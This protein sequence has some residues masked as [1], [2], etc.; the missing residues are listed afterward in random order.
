MRTC[1]FWAAATAASVL[2]F[3]S[4][5]S[6]TPPPE[7][8][9]FTVSNGVKMLKFTPAP[10]I[11]SYNIRSQ[12][13]VVAPFTND[14]SGSIS[15]FSFRVTNNAP[16]KFYNVSA[17]PMSSNNLLIANLLNRIAFGPTPDELQR[18]TNI[19][20]Q[21]YINEQLA[22]DTVVDTLDSYV[23]DTT[24]G[25][26]PPSE[27]QWRNVTVDGAFTATNF[28]V[29]LLAGG[30]AY[31][32]DIELRA[33]DRMITTN[34]PGVGE[35]YTTNYVLSTNLFWNGDFESATLNPW[36]KTAN[37]NNSA[38]STTY[39]HSGS[40][41][42]HLV[43]AT[44]GSTVTDS[45]V[46]RLTNLWFRFD[47]RSTSNRLSFWYLQ[48]TNSSRIKLRLSGEGVNGSGSDVP[49]PPQWI[50]GTATG[51][52]SS[53][54]TIYLYLSGAGQCYVDD[55]K[56]VAGSVPE[57]GVNIARNGD[58]ESPL[59]TNN[60]N[61]TADFTGSSIN[62]NFTHSGAGSLKIVA[63]GAGNGNGDAIFQTN[64]VG[65]TAGAPYT[66]SFWYLPPSN[67]RSLTCRLSGSSTPG[68][69]NANVADPDAPS[70]LRRR[71]DTIR[72]A[73]IDDGTV[74]INTLGGAQ[75][76]DLRSWFVQHC[77][78]DN[79]QLLHVLLQ[80]LENHFVTQS[81]K[82]V[83]Y[84]DRFY[85][86]TILE[87][88]ATD[89]EYREVTKWR[90]ALL[91]P[92]C[93]FYDL[94]RISAESPAMVV[95]LD[96]VDSNGNGTSI[97][98]E[99]YAR[100]IMELFCM[101]V[102]NGYDQQD[103][104]V[105]SRAWSGWSVEIVDPWNINNPHATKASRVGF[106]PGVGTGGTSNLVGVWTF[107]YKTNSHGTNRAAVWSIWNT[108]TVNPQPI[109]VKTVP[110]RFGPP[111]AGQP[112][113]LY[114]TNAVPVRFTTNGIND[115][116]D[117]LAKIAD[118]PFTMEFISVKLCRLFVHDDFVHGVYDYTD[119]NRSAEAELVRQCMIAW[120]TPVGGRK[121]NIR[122]ILNTIFNS[123]LFRSH[124]G[125]LQKVKTPL[126]YAVSTIRSLRA[127]NGSGGYFASTDGY[128]ISGRSRGASSAPLTRMGSMML[129]DR[130]APDGYPEA[131][132]PWISAG[133]LAERIRFVQTTLMNTSE[134]TNKTDNISGG[135]SNLTDPVGL[136]KAKLPSN[137][138]SDAAAVADYFTRIIYP[139]EGRG[140][141]ETYRNL[142]V[143]F[144]NTAED[145]SGNPSA[146]T[147]IP[148][149]DA[150]YDTRVRGVVSMLLTLP[151]F[152]EQ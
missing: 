88:L 95:Y 76:A 124:G 71:F 74:T 77:V 149:S 128:S 10:A 138:W 91:N 1:V 99:N 136:L 121:G 65:I 84:L 147:A 85:D 148:Q 112:Y 113:N 81:S 36:I 144:L 54:R 29:Y 102:D 22:P 134:G 130:D 38:P 107:N 104:T 93:N 105:M 108:N 23:T 42:L 56:L 3:S 53:A 47:N 13:D 2:V 110:A 131:G 59:S 20:P 145:G 111:W 67:G 14:N 11:E 142:A 45:L 21:A 50:Y 79:R 132:P 118:L 17:T 18:L 125:S 70:T 39:A 101:G 44:A 109:G 48:T 86:G 5:A 135:N 94:L 78:G 152:Q 4:L 7:I 25:V 83:D 30:D 31:L 92:N 97:A 49:P 63:T 26:P 64:L 129:F 127:S 9:N 73:S 58:F 55:L 6:D 151:R 141:L 133:T 62:T 139:G 60:W 41:S 100:E 16:V 117:V 72:A 126:E 87:T 19:G 123:D 90:E 140:N 116:Y 115:A 96:S 146:F 68:L 24:N 33:W 27:L 66:V 80:F 143:D 150:R 28:Y 15:N 32:D 120:N 57:V 12:T 43:S 122:S 106:Y 35:T 46:Q 8:S 40:Q 89:W 103:I 98:N 75:V 119:P 61:L 37:V 82:S 34:N 69:L 52:A 114:P 137:Q 51:V